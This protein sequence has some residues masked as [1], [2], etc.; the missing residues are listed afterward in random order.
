MDKD[1]IRK[2]VKLI[3]QNLAGE[4]N[5]QYSNSVWQK[6]LQM[7]EFQNSKTVM[8]YMSFQNEIDTR[9]INLQIKE[10]GKTLL[11][12]RVEKDGMVAVID[13]GKYIKS[14]FGIWEPLGEKYNGEIDLVIV[15]G[16]AFDEDGNRIGF[17]KGYY[18]NFL[19]SYPNA[20]KI[21]P[22]YDWQ[23]FSNFP[24]YKNDIKMD[25]L[26]YFAEK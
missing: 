3:R 7:K 24:V 13:S 5:V 18:D 1:F 25:V 15:P 12:P 8:S 6:L 21:A 17:G 4:E 10:M 20:L 16:L 22:L 23:L 14:K 2:K 11:L 19:K 9:F 26:L